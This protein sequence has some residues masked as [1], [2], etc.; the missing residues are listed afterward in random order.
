[1]FEVPVYKLLKASHTACFEGSEVAVHIL[2]HAE[3]CGRFS[4]GQCGG[5]RGQCTKS[6]LYSA[7]T[8][9]FKFTV[10]LM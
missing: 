7:P 3:S 9:H 4:I 6:R 8:V 5:Y 1:M 10:G 2:F